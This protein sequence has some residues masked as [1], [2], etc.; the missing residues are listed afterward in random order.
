MDE[1]W[2]SFLPLW[3]WNLSS[4]LPFS[5]VWLVC[6]RDSELH[7]GLSLPPLSEGGARQLLPYLEVQ[8]TVCLSSLVS[9]CL[10]SLLGSPRLALKGKG[11][12]SLALEVIHPVLA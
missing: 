2:A 3:G 12:E 8:A 11:A 7:P 4:W 5:E 6:H 9:A 10:F 1:H